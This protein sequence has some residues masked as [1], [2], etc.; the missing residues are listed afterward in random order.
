M[1]NYAAIVF[2]KTKKNN[3]KEAKEKELKDLS[4]WDGIGMLIP[5]T[6][7]KIEFNKQDY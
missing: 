4:Y 6:H 3:I 7:F 5:G 2:F 1:Q